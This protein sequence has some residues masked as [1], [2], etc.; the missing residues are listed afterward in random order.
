MNSIIALIIT[1]FLLLV[2][3][4]FVAAEFA[5][6]SSRRD[7]L[8]NLI[9]AGQT[10]AKKVY[11][12]TEHLSAMLA[13]AQLGVTIASLILGKVSE[14]TIAHLIEEPALHF[15]L[16]EELIHSLGFIIALGIVTV[17]HIILGEMVPKNIALVG[18]ERVAMVVIPI[19]MHFVQV[20]RPIIWVMNHLAALTLKLFGIEQ[21]DELDT[22][23]DQDQLATMISASLSE[24][25][26][27]AEET[28]RL[29]NAL[30]TETRRVTEVMIPIDK[31]RTLAFSPTG[32]TLGEIVDLVEETG[33]SRFPV[34]SS[35]GDAF[36]G[37]LH[38]KDV[39][40]RLIAADGS[41]DERISHQI[42]RPLTNLDASEMLDDALRAM[43]RKSVHI[44]Q[45]RD[46]GTV[47]G[48]VAMEDLIEEYV[49]T[50]NDWT[51]ETN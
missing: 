47:V 12:A 20:V 46:N 42:L 22:N 6:I 15:G 21:K 23:I 10:R 41:R 32:P 33:Y 48:I 8:E 16:P 34:T 24:G 2:N 9:E 28:L 4:F 7:R 11:Y 45:V 13:G 25:L 44:A 31:V 39:L 27:D 17:L 5:L 18:P 1:L 40:D 26:L 19:H 3:A 51:H 38:V 14:P 43:R 50:V 30:S 29:T 37:Y 35:A 49:G 36:I